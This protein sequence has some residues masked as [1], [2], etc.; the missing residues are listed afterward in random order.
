MFETKLHDGLN[1]LEYYCRAFLFS[2]NHIRQFKKQLKVV[3]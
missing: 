3:T 1:C 2:I